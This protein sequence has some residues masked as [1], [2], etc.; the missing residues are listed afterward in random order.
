MEAQR[1]TK[2]NAL[3]THGGS[4]ETKWT[5]LGQYMKARKDRDKTGARRRI[6]KKIRYKLRETL[7][8]TKKNGHKPNIY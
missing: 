2:D 5:N 3:T 8:I 6:T 7:G 4:K 1:K